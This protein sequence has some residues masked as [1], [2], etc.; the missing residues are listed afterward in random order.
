MSNGTKKISYDDK[1]AL[2]ENHS[3][4]CLLNANDVNELVQLM[5]EEHKQPDEI[6]VHEGDPVDKIYF[7]AE[8][9]AEVT[10]DISTVEKTA[11]MH[12]SF[13]QN[14]DVIGL[15]QT[16]LFSTSG[17][18]TARVTAVS[19]I[20][21]LTIKLSNFYSLSNYPALKEIGEKFLLMNFIKQTDKLSH[22]STDKV[23]QLSKRI[24][25]ITI[26]ASKT[27]FSKNEPADKYYFLLSGEVNLTEDQQVV[28]VLQSGA[29][30]G[31]SA[32]SPNNVR[33]ETAIT[34]TDC[35]LF[36]LDQEIISS[37]IK[38]SKEFSLW[39]KL[40]RIFFKKG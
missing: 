24:Q 7:I 21:L 32:L 4:F 8:G 11:F 1:K 13:L 31:E 10:R 15:A 19:S 33:A 12:L 35:D 30:F 17:V 27:I 25:K 38:Q 40:K 14:G 23:R 37:I 28:S 36:Q 34:K 16:G 26:P 39:V 18:R 22:L 3:F 29:C 20:I 2:V 5:Q 6:I 9:K